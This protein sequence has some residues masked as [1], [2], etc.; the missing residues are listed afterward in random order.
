M[1]VKP[2][3]TSKGLR[4][5]NAVTLFSVK[6]YGCPAFA[7]LCRKPKVSDP[8]LKN[9]A[10]SLYRKDAKIGS[11]STADAIRHENIT[12]EPVGGAFHSTKGTEAIRSLENWGKKST[13][14]S[15]ADRAAA[16]NMAADLRD[17]LG[18]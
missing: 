4:I 12:G 9:I 2:N 17:A 5:T 14:A 11:G 15:S 7:G 1:K 16:E 18:Y 10:D 13:N 3:A 6:S 8:K